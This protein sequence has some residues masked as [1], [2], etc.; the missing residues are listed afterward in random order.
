MIN[1]INHRIEAEMAIAALE[2]VYGITAVSASRAELLMDEREYVGTARQGSR[3]ACRALRLLG[4][5]EQELDVLWAHD[6]DA[7]QVYAMHYGNLIS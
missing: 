5:T 4:W 3:I 6:S 1:Y 2:R 7:E